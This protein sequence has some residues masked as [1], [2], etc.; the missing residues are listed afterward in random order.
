MKERMFSKKGTAAF[1]YSFGIRVY[2]GGVEQSGLN[3]GVM[4]SGGGCLTTVNS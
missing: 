4:Y 2:I 1:G 3:A